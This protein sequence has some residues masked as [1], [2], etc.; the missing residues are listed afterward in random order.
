MVAPNTED[1]N[2]Q[3]HFLTKFK[4][5]ETVSHHQATLDE[6]ER[7]TPLFEAWEEHTNIYLDQQKK[8]YPA[9]SHR[10]LK[11]LQASC[12]Q[13]VSAHN[14]KLAFIGIANYSQNIMISGAT[15]ANL[16]DVFQKIDTWNEKSTHKTK[17]STYLPPKNKILPL[18]G[19]WCFMQTYR[20]QDSTR[21]VLP[22]LGLQPKYKVNEALDGQQ[23]II[24]SMENIERY[25]NHDWLHQIRS[26]SIN[27]N[28]FFTPSF[29][30]RFERKIGGI[31]RKK[32]KCVGITGEDNLYESFFL[33]TQADLLKTE[34]AKGLWAGLN[35]ETQL[36]CQSLKERFDRIDQT[37]PDGIEH[38]KALHYLARTTARILQ[39]VEPVH[40]PL[41]QDFL[42]HAIGA[43]P[44]Q[45]A[46]AKDTYKKTWRTP[47]DAPNSVD[48][49]TQ[50]LI[51]QASK[52][53]LLTAI[54][55]DGKFAAATH[56]N[57]AYLAQAMKYAPK[58]K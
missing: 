6:A 21:I 42:K 48:G 33:K 5:A 39:R 35:S 20:D 7:L 56:R 34:S 37:K 41:I 47:Q 44:P 52:T 26:S 43:M 55:E 3:Q 46:E 54:H 14:L 36:L 28:A 23:S 53:N 22:M 4:W 13:P 18:Y 38:F 50:G 2:L 31:F 45:T 32:P 11:F 27:N 40:S 24:T 12:T 8:R 17:R 15:I 1:F 58:M 16:P 57:A 30:Y 51:K 9:W 49:A 10:A 19:G 25:V 29:P